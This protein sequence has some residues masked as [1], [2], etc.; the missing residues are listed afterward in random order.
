VSRFGWFRAAIWAVVCS[1]WPL[2]VP[3]AWWAREIGRVRKAPDFVPE[4][5][6]AQYIETN[7]LIA[8]A[9]T[10]GAIKFVVSLFL[11][12]V[13]TCVLVDLRR[14]R[15]VRT[16]RIAIELVGAAMCVGAYFVL[17]ASIRGGMDLSLLVPSALEI[18]PVWSVIAAGMSFLAVMRARTDSPVAT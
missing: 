15:G 11:L 16:A 14:R 10:Y 8:T 5:L 12:S 4:Q 18:L 6:R 1:L 2:S 7:R 17:S 3:V 13:V 9:M